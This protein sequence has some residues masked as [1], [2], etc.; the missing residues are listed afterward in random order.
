MSNDEFQLYE[1]DIS[2]FFEDQVFSL[3][4]LDRRSKH[5]L[6][7]D[8]EYVRSFYKDAIAQV[9]YATYLPGEYWVNRDALLD[10]KYAD[11]DRFDEEQKYWILVR[12][13]NGDM[14]C[15]FTVY[16]SKK[17]IRCQEK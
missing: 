2:H 11:A 17:I 9:F 4:R 13:V 14:D 3:R 8:V 7:A 10:A 5:R 16:I 15:S 12:F 6:F 1:E